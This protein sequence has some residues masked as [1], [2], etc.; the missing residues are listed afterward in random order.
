M[1]PE[2]APAR[3]IIDA[4]VHVSYHQSSTQPRVTSMMI[5]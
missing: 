3:D 5:S 4:E 2:V 1:A